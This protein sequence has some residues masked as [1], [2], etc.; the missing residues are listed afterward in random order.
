MRKCAVCLKKH[1]SGAGHFFVV[2]TNDLERLVWSESCRTHLGARDYVC[3]DHF[4]RADM[5]CGGTQARLLAKAIPLAPSSQSSSSNCLPNKRNF[6]YVVQTLVSKNLNCV[7]WFSTEI[8]VRNIQ[9]ADVSQHTSRAN[10]VFGSTISP[11]PYT[12]DY[13]GIPDTRKFR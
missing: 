8:G 12:S 13:V 11:L 1:K 2:P 3:S 6:G 5:V 10:N 4:S 9:V 7:F